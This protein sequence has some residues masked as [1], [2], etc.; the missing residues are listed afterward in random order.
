M[1]DAPARNRY[2]PHSTG[3]RAALTQRRIR[4]RRWL[5]EGSNKQSPLRRISA[6]GCRYYAFALVCLRARSLLSLDC[7]PKG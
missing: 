1:P 6:G 3:M 7:S 4:R 5:I 2:A